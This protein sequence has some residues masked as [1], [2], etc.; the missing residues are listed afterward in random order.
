VVPGCGVS[1]CY[2]PSEICV[3]VPAGTIPVS[4]A[5]YYDSFSGWGEFTNERQTPNG[6]CAT[7][8]QHSHNVTRIVSFDVLYQFKNVPEGAPLPPTEAEMLGKL[9][10]GERLRLSA[11]TRK[12]SGNFLQAVVSQLKDS[13][14]LKAKGLDIEGADFS[15]DISITK[16]TIPFPV[17]LINCRFTKRFSVQDA[18]SDGSLV[19]AGSSFE[20]SFQFQNTGIKED[21]S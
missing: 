18:R 10:L 15:G 9:K 17:H 7:Y 11:S 5:H 13:Q 19:V 8:V 16:T 3:D 14:V 21:L 1:G 4:I 20:G 2:A 6:F 12:I